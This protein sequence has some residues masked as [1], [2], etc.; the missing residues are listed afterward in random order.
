M[1]DR[2]SASRPARQAANLLFHGKPSVCY[3]LVQVESR[4]SPH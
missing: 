3:I 2:G 1:C 4:P